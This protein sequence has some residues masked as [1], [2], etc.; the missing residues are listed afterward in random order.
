M[1]KGDKNAGKENRRGRK[2]KWTEPGKD[3]KTM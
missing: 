2:K 3:G 1:E